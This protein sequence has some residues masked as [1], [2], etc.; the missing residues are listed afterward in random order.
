[1][2]TALKSILLVDDNETLLCATQRRLQARGFAVFTAVCGASALGIASRHAPDVAIVDEIM[3]GMSGLELAR[4]LKQHQPEITVISLSGMGDPLPEEDQDADQAVDMYHA[5]L[6]KP[7]DMN[8]L[9]R[10]LDS[11]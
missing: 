7:L 4:K 6:T 1:M 2:N 8:T 5:I 11:I 3:P 10:I 9:E